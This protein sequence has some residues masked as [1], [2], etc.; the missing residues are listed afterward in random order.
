MRT[1]RS[2]FLKGVGLAVAGGLGSFA[3]ARLLASQE[4]A[5]QGSAHDRIDSIE[6]GLF[7]LP[8]K[9]VAITA[10]GTLSSRNVLVRLRTAGGVTGLGESSPFTPVTGETAESNLALVPDL[11][12]AVRGR[13]PFAVARIVGGMAVKNGIVTLPAGPGLG[14]DVDG[15]FLRTV[16][17]M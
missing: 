15:E 3:P 11:A 9:V 10:V 17:A 7:V 2:S 4:K 5:A 13:D 6:A 12:G 8:D 16:R 14:A 1:T